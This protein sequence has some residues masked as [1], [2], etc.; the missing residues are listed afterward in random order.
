M[1]LLLDVLDR[2]L[3]IAPKACTGHSL[4]PAPSALNLVRELYANRL[5]DAPTWRSSPWRKQFGKA[6]LGPVVEA[7]LG[8][9]GLDDYEPTTT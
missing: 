5:L 3:D 4:R 1:T 2:Q 8:R 6:A 7:A 9:Q